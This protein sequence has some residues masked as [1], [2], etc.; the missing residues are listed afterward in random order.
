VVRAVY[1]PGEQP[2]SFT[3]TELARGPW[4]PGAQNGSAP[5]ALLARALEQHPG[6][7]ELALARITIELLRPVPIDALELSIELVRPGRRAQ[8][9]DAS[10]R[11][12]DGTEVVR[13]RGVKLRRADVDA[14]APAE[15]APPPP[16]VGKPDDFNYRVRPTFARDAMEIRFVEGAYHQ[17]GPATAWFRLRADLVSGETPSPLQRLAA[18]A[19]FPNGISSVLGWSTWTFIN[20]DLTIHIERE[21]VGEWIGL[22]AQTRVHTGGL[23]FA[24]AAL[25]DRD[26]RVGRSLQSLLV[27]PRADR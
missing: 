20:P 23:G 25:Y 16:E 4:D 2:G 19:D 10:L 18:A 24:E 22:R 6:G 9:L 26:G 27:S 21:P 12:A 7:E 13:A 8:L 1:I 5:A 14:G 15:P 17:R 11:T 3:A